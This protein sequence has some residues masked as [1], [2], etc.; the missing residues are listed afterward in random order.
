MPQCNSAVPDYPAHL[1]VEYP[2]HLSRGLIFVKWLLIVPH[3][4]IVSLFT[5]G[6]AWA[7]WQIRDSS[8]SSAGWAAGGLIFV[9]VVVAGFSLLFRN[10]YP[11]SIFDL[12]MG[13]DRWCLR[14]VPYVAL[15]SDVYPPFRL[16]QGGHDPDQP[17]MPPPV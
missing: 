9:L 8:G 2:D 14:V 6:G 15:M 13:L 7:T 4:L 3:L 16:D 1:W 11:R 17:P 12:V 5:G 10:E